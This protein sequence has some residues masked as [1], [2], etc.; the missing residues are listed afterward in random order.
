[1]LYEVITRAVAHPHGVLVVESRAEAVRLVA[2]AAHE[3]GAVLIVVG[4]PLLLSGARGELT[5]R[6]DRFI[7]ALRKETGVPIVTWDERLSTAEATRVLRMDREGRRGG[8]GARRPV[9]TSYSIHY[10]KLYDR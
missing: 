7:D 9:I 8:R 5:R 6:V 1:M 2:R 4:Y 10:T 3:E